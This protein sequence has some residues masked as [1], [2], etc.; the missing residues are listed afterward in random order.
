MERFEV[1]DAVGQLAT[2]QPDAELVADVVP[3]GFGVVVEGDAASGFVTEPLDVE[4][5][6]LGKHLV[7][8]DV[9][10][11]KLHV[12]RHHALQAVVVDVV[13][14]DPEVAGVDRRR[15]GLHG[16]RHPG[17]LFGEADVA[18][19]CVG[20]VAVVGFDLG[21]AA[22]TVVDQDTETTQVGGGEVLVIVDGGDGRRRT[23][24]VRRHREAG[25]VG[26]VEDQ[27]V[28]RLCHG[29]QVVD[30]VLGQF[31]VPAIVGQGAE[32]HR[33]QVQMVRIGGHGHLPVVDVVAGQVVGPGGELGERDAV[34][35]VDDV[36]ER[37]LDVA[38]GHL[39]ATLQQP[40]VLDVGRGAVVVTHVLPLG[41][42]DAVGGVD[43]HDEPGAV[44]GQL[45][46][47]PHEQELGQLAQ[48]LVLELRISQHLGDGDDLL[49][50][51]EVLQ[52]V[53]L[54]AL[55]E[56]LRQEVGVRAGREAALD[57]EFFVE[58]E[59][60]QRA[61]EDLLLTHVPLETHATVPGAASNVVVR[62]VDDVRMVLVA[63][64]IRRIGHG[65]PL[66]S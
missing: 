64:Q 39:G 37:R 5:L 1:L 7:Q 63:E 41:G 3:I 8:V 42:R 20:E 38:V 45:D 33:Q 2:H 57:V 43:G 4:P 61:A 44:L 31:D 13:L 48:V 58:G 47:E 25:F 21:H 16:N 17:L 66:L 35:G 10:E 15:A 30:E 32:A 59:V 60:R 28:G 22:V 53:A 18:H 12:G 54:V 26:F 14:P 40:T 34:L 19:G 50:L 11:P 29:V 55:D 51:D 27:D 6:L 46:L 56:P 36:V 49:I 52:D 23:D 65:M 62:L 24:E 9:R